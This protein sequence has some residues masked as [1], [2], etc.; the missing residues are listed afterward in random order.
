MAVRLKLRD[1]LSPG[2]SYHLG[3]RS[4]TGSFRGTLH[5]HDFAEV[6]WI[7]RGSL[8][9]VINGE[10]R[11][12][13]EGD[14]V[15]VRPADVHTFRSIGGGHFAQVSLAFAGDT[16]DVLE[17]RYFDDAA[18]PWAQ[19]PLPTTQRLERVRFARL[20]ELALLLAGG[21]PSR[22]LL[23]RFLLELLHDLTEPAA[24]NALPSWLNDALTRFTDD[25]DALARGAPGLAALAGRS[26]EHVNRVIRD[27]TGST[28]TA[29]INE[30][31][32]TRAAAELRMTDRPIVTIAA[33][34][35]I[36]SVSHFY[37]LFNARFGVTP[38]HYRLGQQTLIRG[39][40]RAATRG[41][42]LS[43]G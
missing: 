34:C 25:P 30:I 8:V 35:G 21:P 31:R 20:G 3:R 1:Y 5:T 22:L 41:N 27:R 29:A 14:V 36:S 17:R 32:L 42:C 28:T 39:S 16:L 23:E 37:R 6:L 4:A 13:S 11:R 40:G 43:P 38:R 15:F 2:A 12:L 9:H 19:A 33:D 10:R 7:E 26:P 18:W 24:G